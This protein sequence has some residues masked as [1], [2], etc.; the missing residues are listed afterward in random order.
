MISSTL[1]QVFLNQ[2]GVETRNN[3]INGRTV[4]KNEKLLYVF[5]FKTSQY[6]SLQEKLNAFDATTTERTNLGVIEWFAPSFSGPE[7]FDVFDVNGFKIEVRH[8]V[9]EF[10]NE[11][12]GVFHVIER[13]IG[14]NAV[15]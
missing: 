3:R 8:L 13:N 1:Q 12:Y 5:F 4:R 11:F 14:H 9:S 6:N 15:A 10:F 2:G 7:K